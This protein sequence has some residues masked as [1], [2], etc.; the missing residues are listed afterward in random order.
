M[1][2]HIR[3]SFGLKLS[4][5]I[6][7]I[8]I[9]IFL[10]VRV[11]TYYTYKKL[12]LEDISQNISGLE[13]S[14]LNE[15]NTLLLP[16]AKTA[17]LLASVI[18]HTSLSIPEI[19]LIEQDILES[20]KAINGCTI[21]FEPYK[22]LKDKYYFDPGYQRINGVIKRFSTNNDERYDYFNKEWYTKAKE[23][24]T[25]I[26]SEPYFDAGGGDIMMITYS[27][28]F[29]RMVNGIKE[30]YGVIAMDVSL[31]S[32]NE[33]I[34]KI[35]VFD[36]GYAFLLSSKGTFIAHKEKKYYQQ[37]MSVFD[38]A[39][40]Y[41]FSNIKQIAKE[42]VA[43]KKGSSIYFS[44]TLQ[45]NCYI[46]Y[47]PFYLTGWSIGI[48]V[49]QDELFSRPLSTALRTIEAG[50]IGYIMIFVFIFIFSS[51]MTSP[52]KKLA[53]AANK[54]GQGN[55]NIEIP[56]VKSSDEIKVL[57]D[58]FAIM[59]KNLI[60]YIQTLK[61]TVA[62]KEKIERDIAIAREIQESLIPRNFPNRKEFDIFAKLIPAR[63]VAGDLY[64]F[65]MVDDEHL[66]FAIGDVSGKGI[67][68]SLFMA[69]TKTLLR[70]KI[71]IGIEPAA[72]M[73]AI[74]TELCRENASTM[75]VT[76]FIG[77]LDIRNG[78]LQYCNAGHNSPLLKDRDDLVYLCQN[79]SQPS[80][81]ILDE[82]KYSNTMIKLKKDDVFF[83]YTDGIT[84]AINKD[85]SEFSETKLYEVVD[86]NKNANVQ[87]IVCSV[88]SAVSEHANGAEQSDDITVFVLKYNG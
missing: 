16:A 82:A 39:E 65:L 22:F 10:S 34:S 72:I 18:S 32:I 26:W 61:E 42:M 60:N 53:I 21:A 28:P 31:Y 4:L 43:L 45:K 79:K 41:D 66:C 11:Y 36:T 59:Q 69:V 80:L 13:V 17:E 6:I 15:V 56:N 77:I 23:S 30:L 58:S 5:S 3:L 78:E 24:G 46:Y 64:D 55:F 62:A 35:K 40:K 47:Q 7:A 54:I 8:V 86:Q 71:A 85:N 84:E 44:P 68:A 88:L 48:V 12:I 20:N 52:L 70:S 87:D 9:A 2:I 49:P 75:F 63:D 33:M 67:P 81:G 14:T 27:C 29:Y 37:N 83:L 74:N 57:S 51:K 76:F 25:G 38:L 1:K 19:E 50:M 73:T